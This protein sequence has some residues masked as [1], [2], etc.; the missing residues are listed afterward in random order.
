MYIYIYIY[1]YITALLVSLLITNNNEFAKLAT[2][3]GTI[4]S[5]YSIEITP[6][7][8]TRVTVSKLFDSSIKNFFTV[9]QND[10]Y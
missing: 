3:F 2:N 8:S 6:L 9:S 7:F 10:C 5:K 4:V 1:I